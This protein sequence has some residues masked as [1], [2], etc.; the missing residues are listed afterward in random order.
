ME[1][2]LRGS[3]SLTH[4]IINQVATLL[5]FHRVSKFEHLSQYLGG[6]GATVC[7]PSLKWVDVL[8]ELFPGCY[9]SC[10]SGSVGM[11]HKDIEVDAAGCFYDPTKAQSF[12]ST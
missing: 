8:E 1:P 9:H 6:G 11:T 5:L 2:M 10:C 4:C 7:I 3:M 12:S